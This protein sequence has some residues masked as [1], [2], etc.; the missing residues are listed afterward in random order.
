[1]DEQYQR[2]FTLGANDAKNY[3][4]WSA[5]GLMMGYGDLA[6]WTEDEVKAYRD[7]YQSVRGKRT[8]LE[9]TI[10]DTSQDY[11]IKEFQEWERLNSLRD[12]PSATSDTNG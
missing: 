10:L 6:N 5:N 9:E 1:M 3:P 8:E 4:T 2:L 11:R 12:K 7:G